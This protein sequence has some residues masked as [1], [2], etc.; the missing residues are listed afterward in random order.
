MGSAVNEA[1]QL[2]AEALH[3]ASRQCI[4]DMDE[5]I[6]EG[7][8]KR[9]M[10]EVLS[11][12]TEAGFL[13]PAGEETSEIYRSYDPI[14]GSSFLPGPDRAQVEEWTARSRRP[15]AAW[16]LTPNPCET[17]V[18]TQTIWPDGTVMTSPWRP[19]TDPEGA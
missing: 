7:E 19:V 2:I 4:L 9:A 1:G 15:T 12:L 11:V 13:L 16:S 14:S 17:Q 6:A 3:R 18:A 8:H 10:L 5:C